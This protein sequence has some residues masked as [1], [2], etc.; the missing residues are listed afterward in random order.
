MK[1]NNSI[2]KILLVLFLACAAGYLS[3][4]ETAI[5]GVRLVDVYGL[6]G[7]LFLNALSLVV[8]PL[9]ASS[10]ILGAARIG[11]EESMGSLG[12]KT[13]SYFLLTIT[14][15]VL[16]GY[17]VMGLFTPGEGQS[18]NFSQV[19]EIALKNMEKV[20]PNGGFIQ[21]KQLFLKLIPSNILAAASQGQMMGLILFCLLFGYFMMKI[22]ESASQV[23]V[24][25]WKGLFEV[26]MKMT[27]FIM[28]ALPIGVFGLVA[29]V[30]ATS[31]SEAFYSITWFFG[32]ALLAFG[33][34]GLIV[35]P[36]LLK[37]VAGVSPLAHVKAMV[38]ALLTA[39]STSSSAAS[40][41]VVIE[42]VEKEAGVSNRVCGFSIPL[43]TAVNLS[44]SAMYAGMVVFFIAQVSGIALPFSTQALIVVMAILSSFGMAGIPSA[45]LIAVVAILHAVGLPIEALGLVFAI[46]RLLDMF[47]TATNVFAN[48]CCAVLIANSEGEELKEIRS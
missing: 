48:T 21:I 23:M 2:V 38:P 14:L 35:L 17:L 28:K 39:F 47:R 25:F 1:N 19:S 20:S 26:M 45:S 7:E 18:L 5:F 32:S 27:Q 30:V 11:G 10:I 42:C 36:F 3:G 9:V 6:I 16:I 4:S 15:A 29:R 33:I 8:V 31:G 44:A 34:Y 40:L 43:G 37:Y 12:I 24:G 46:E 41:P 22:D 13:F